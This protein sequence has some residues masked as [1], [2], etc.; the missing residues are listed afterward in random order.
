MPQSCPPHVN[1][2]TNEY[3]RLVGV[4]ELPSSHV[5]EMLIKAYFHY[6]HPFFPVV[7][8]KRFIETFES[9]RRNEL[10]IHLL[11]SMFL[12]AANVCATSI[13]MAK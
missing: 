7:E 12:A 3:L 11:W 4:F 6:V 5:C 1:T 2:A 10:S 8:A 9:P 13:G